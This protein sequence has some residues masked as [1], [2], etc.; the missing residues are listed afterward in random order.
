MA[1]EPNP[2]WA[3]IDVYTDTVPD[4]GQRWRGQRRTPSAMTSA[5]GAPN[6]SGYQGPDAAAVAVERSTSWPA[7]A[8]SSEAVL[9][10]FDDLIG[11][12]TSPS[13]RE[14]KSRRDQR[15]ALGQ[16]VGWLAGFDGATWQQRWLHA[17]LNDL[18]KDWTH[19]VHLAGAAGAYDSRHYRSMLLG[20]AKAL[21]VLDV[22]RPSYQWLFGY[23]STPGYSEIRA[24]RDQHGFESLGDLARSSLPGF[25]RHDEESAFKHLARILVHNG[26]AIT[27]VTLADCREAY[28]A[29]LA[30]GGNRK[31]VWYWML[32]HGG[33]LGDDAPRHAQG[34]THVGQRTVTELVDGYGIESRPVRDLLIDYLEERRPVVDYSTIAQLA[35][36]LGL[37]F[38]RDIER[39]EPGID[40]LDLPD[41]VVRRWK[42]RLG[43]VTYGRRRV[44]QR[45]EDPNAIMIA[46]RGLYSD[47]N[48][49]AIEDPARWARWAAPNPIGARDLL[50]QNKHKS[51]A[52]A[53][54]HQRTRELAPLV[55]ALVSSAD[56]QRRHAA[57]LLAA[58]RNTRH[59]D[60][61]TVAGETLTRVVVAADP[62][63]GGRGR[64]GMV[65]ADQ[66]DGTRRNLVREEDLIF[67]GWAIIE[68]LRH[69][70]IRIEELTELTHRSFVAYTLPTSGETIPLLQITP[71]KSDKER[72]LVVSPE[73]ADVLATIIDRVR[74]SN[75]HVPLITRYDHAERTHSPMLPFLFQRRLGLTNSMITTSAAGGLVTR[76]VT[77]SAIT[78]TDGTPAHFTPHDFRRIFATDA[79]AAGLPVHIAAKVLGHDNLNTTQAYVAVYDRDVIDHHR[80]YIARRRAQRP[81]TEYRDVTDDEWDE[82]LSHFEHRKVELGTCGRAYATPC[83][84]EHA[85][86]RCPLLRPDP[87]QLGRLTEIEQ[88]LHARITE[89]HQRGWTGEIEGLQISLAGATHKLEQMRHH[90]HGDALQLAVAAP[91][92]RPKAPQ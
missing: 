74:A 70:G 90:H 91:T 67:W 24:S 84:H 26:G 14:R 81:S 55:P 89:A 29:Q 63:N 13:E 43:T 42:Q 66:P 15:R 8:A 69:T 47:I 23:L 39:H 31:T 68:V 76:I 45:R 88:N 7:T 83:V 3:P 16:F 49:W 33:A 73:L 25:N 53:R 40:S 19:G 22:V 12:L 37:L 5:P 35:S 60:T 64:E 20:A 32:L 6:T 41:D 1:A 77:R 44:G 36:K 10:R 57:E 92:L 61:F 17:G 34:L 48:H 9:S 30:Y 21:L 86:V 75:D 62:A 58:A 71:S 51:K 27:D 87:A 38:W 46:V 28:A 79:V 82:F 18:G 50:G 4:P 52:R 78:H 72:L 65:W 80:A 56:Q 2:S 54:M 59:G 11:A 85:C